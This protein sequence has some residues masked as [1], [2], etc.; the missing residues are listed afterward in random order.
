VAVNRINTFR[1]NIKQ[2]IAYPNLSP[3]LQ[4]SRHRARASRRVAFM[5][6]LLLSS[7][8]RASL[9]AQV[10]RASDDVLTMTS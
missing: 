6:A 4:D 9:F 10:F 1:V 8:F 7:L 2:N 5:S 3:P